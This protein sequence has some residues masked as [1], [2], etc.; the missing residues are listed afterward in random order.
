MPEYRT[1][2]FPTHLTRWFAL[3]IGLLMAATTLADAAPIHPHLGAQLIEQGA[4]VLD[5]RAPEEVE[6]T[7]LLANAKNVVHTD[8][9]GLKAAVGAD[10]QR[11]VV[12]YCASG[13][14]AEM[15]MDSLREAGYHNLINAGGYD[16]L[17]AAL[18]D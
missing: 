7:G 3:A 17:R 9:E 8:T 18:E 11:M 14:R 15:A 6:A 1:R 4:L 16:D 5:V 12:V 13:R 10:R 2:F